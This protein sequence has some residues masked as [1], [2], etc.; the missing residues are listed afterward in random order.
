MGVNDGLVSQNAR[1]AQPLHLRRGPDLSMTQ[2]SSA[3]TLA[4]FGGAAALALLLDQPAQAHGIAPGGIA[5][6]FPSSDQRR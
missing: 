4:L 6:G 1:R 3:R 2:I 5:A